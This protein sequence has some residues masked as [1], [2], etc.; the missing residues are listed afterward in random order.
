M[1]RQKVV[2]LIEGSD[3]KHTM[4]VPVGNQSFVTSFF[5]RGDVWPVAAISA[6]QEP[7]AK[8]MVHG[9]MA[10][11]LVATDFGWRKIEDIA[12]G[13]LVLTFDNGLQKVMDICTSPLIC[14]TSHSAEHFW[15]LSV[16]KGALGNR[17]AMELLADQDVLIESELADDLL[18]ETHVLI[19]AQALVGYKGI[20]RTAPVRETKVVSIGFAHDEIVHANGSALL[21]CPRLSETQPVAGQSTA[22]AGL[23]TPYMRLSSL[24]QAR[25]AAMLKRESAVTGSLAL[26]NL[27]FQAAST[28]RLSS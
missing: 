25:L 16:P 8:S 28:I 9:L 1:R 24:H 17:M 23:D 26:A 20:K 22:N 3:M 10:G 14:S 27:G 11:T 7:K 18:G 2:T 21:H 5:D 12:V 19:Q 13:D 4:V 15:P 6:R